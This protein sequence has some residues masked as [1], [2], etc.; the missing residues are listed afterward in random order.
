MG[1]SGTQKYNGKMTYC[2]LIIYAFFLANF[3]G[4]KIVDRPS[5]NDND[6]RHKMTCFQKVIKL[7]SIHE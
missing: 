2:S 3:V 4:T 5:I 7:G 1:H 6:G